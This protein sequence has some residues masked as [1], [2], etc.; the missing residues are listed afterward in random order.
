MI[1]PTD[2]F[3]LDGKSVNLTVL[4][5]WTWGF[6]DLLDNTLRDTLA[7]F[8]VASACGTLDTRQD[9][10]PYDCTSPSGRHIEVK[11]A[12][13]LQSWNDE[14]LSHIQFDIAPKHYWDAEY[15]Y[16]PTKTRNCDLYVFAVYTALSKN[17]SIL[18]LDL[19]DFYVLPTHILD[20]NIPTQKSIS[21]QSLLRFQPTKTN[22]ADL[23]SA[24][25]GV[26]L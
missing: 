19:W 15:G 6:S 10:R 21:L 3:T 17:Q 13:Y 11:C 4:D 14:N 8:L 22:Y 2:Q 12:T 5:F 9:W 18:D 23:L 24:I 26:Q 7:E 20:D 16:S 1:I 25:E